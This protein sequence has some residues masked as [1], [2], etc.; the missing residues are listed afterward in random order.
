M[1]TS[2]HFSHGGQGQSFYNINGNGIGEGSCPEEA[3]ALVRTLD[4]LG[5]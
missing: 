3:G 4:I 5:L 1:S 2:Y